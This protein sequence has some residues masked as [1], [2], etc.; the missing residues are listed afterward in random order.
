MLS[1][2]TE[3]ASYKSKQRIA[4]VTPELV[5]VYKMGE[6]SQ[7]WWVISVTPTLVRMRQEDCYVFE[8]GLHRESQASLGYSLKFYFRNNKNTQLDK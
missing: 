3:S 4:S 7:V 8:A 6:Q 5:I 1:Y 2:Y